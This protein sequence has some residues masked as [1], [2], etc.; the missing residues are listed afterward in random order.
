MFYV[1]RFTMRN[2]QCHFHIRILNNGGNVMSNDKLIRKVFLEDCPA[3]DKS[4]EVEERERIADLTIKGDAVTYRE[5]YYYCPCAD[6][7][8]QEFVIGKMINANLLAA[9]NAYR[10]KHNLLT[11][12]EIINIR[13]NYGLSQVSLAKL[14]GWGEATIS[15]YESKGIQDE[16][17]DAILR[18]I[19]D[20]SLSA[21]QL[22][23]RNKDKFTKLEFINIKQKIKRQLD[24]HG[25]EYLTRRT[26]RSEYVDYLTPS[27]YNGYTSLNIDKIEDMFSYFAEN[28]DHL[29]KVKL[30]KLL[31]YS[32]ALSVKL[33]GYALT[34]LVYQHEAMGALPIGHY[35]LVSLENINMVEELSKNWNTRQHF[36]PSKF[37]DSTSLNDEDKQILD[38]VIA[39]FK[40]MKSNE[41][42]AYMHSE[43][44]YLETKNDQIISFNLAKQIREFS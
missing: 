18:M 16:S 17:H 1:F 6:K 19:K 7:N 11:S 30:M 24:T 35:S 22:L 2:I 40:L 25:R 20:D 34:G 27:E 44:A 29:Y 12:D 3:C 13:K 21:L 37:R 15:R 8:E 32:D 10:K 31:W 23:D 9:R 28:V 43:K 39:K 4:H 41:I 33:R 42:V 14:L 38:Q 36:L 26:L 5:H